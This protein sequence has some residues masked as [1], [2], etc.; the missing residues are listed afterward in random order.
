MNA[1]APA[2][3]SFLLE[4]DKI[5]WDFFHI[6]FVTLAR[7]RTMSLSKLFEYVPNDENLPNG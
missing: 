5:S 2:N 7:V 1:R 4:K 6:L 3:C